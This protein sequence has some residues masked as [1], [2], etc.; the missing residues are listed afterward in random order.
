[1]RVSVT[2]DALVF[3]ITF[4]FLLSPFSFLLSPFSSLVFFKSYLE[5]LI[6]IGWGLEVLLFLLLLQH[7]QSNNLNR[8]ALSPAQP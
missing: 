3:F 2:Y 7:P 4:V 6:K 8:A 1:M 5:I